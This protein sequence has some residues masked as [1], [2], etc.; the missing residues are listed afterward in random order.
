MT[1]PLTA[2]QANAV[3]DLLVQHAGASEDG[4]DDF[5]S[6]QT[7]G[8]VRECPLGGA[9][10]AFQVILHRFDGWPYVTAG[11]EHTRTSSKLRQQLEDANEALRSVLQRKNEVRR[12]AATSSDLA[13]AR[14]F[15]QVD[16]D[17]PCWEWTGRTKPSGYGVFRINPMGGDRLA[18]RTSYEMLV[19]PIPDGLE[20]DHL[21]RVRRC[22]NPDHLEPVTHQE[23]VRRSAAPAALNARKRRC[24]KGHE[25]DRVI[26][27]GSGKRVR[28]C[29]QCVREIRD[30]PT[31]STPLTA[32]D[33]AAICAKYAAGGVTQIELGRQY[34]IHQSQI[35]RILRMGLAEAP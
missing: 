24:L 26:T 29:S 27:L 35:S 32:E 18:H 23:N 30:Y 12:D 22:V 2:A 4:R 8:Y 5:V 16:A 3:Y 31:R 11:R 34:L 14:F 1:A 21:C 17:G 25:F 15:S 10:S 6:T 13:V 33:K 28:K 19:G 9:L 7:K 20:L